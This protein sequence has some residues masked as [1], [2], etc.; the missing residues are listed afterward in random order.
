M[1]V[2][3]RANVIFLFSL[4]LAACGGSSS[5]AGDAVE[6]FL[7]AIEWDDQE[8]VQELLHSEADVVVDMGGMFTFDMVNLLERAA[9]EISHRDGISRIEIVSEQAVELGLANIELVDAIGTDHVQRVETRITFGD[10]SQLEITW[11]LAMLF[12]RYQILEIPDFRSG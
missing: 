9:E 8:R 11:L 6:D 1:M 3:R 10:G 2:T 4:L 5:G 7:R 12:E